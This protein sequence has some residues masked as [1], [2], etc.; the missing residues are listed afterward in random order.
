[1]PRTAFLDFHR[2]CLI[3]RHD[4]APFDRDGAAT[5]VCLFRRRPVGVPLL[6]RPSGHSKA[7]LSHA[8]RRS[9]CGMVGPTMWLAFVH[10][11]SAPPH[12][13]PVARKA[14]VNAARPHAPSSDQWLLQRSSIRC[15][16]CRRGLLL[17]NALRPLRFAVERVCN[18]AWESGSPLYASS[19]AGE[20]A[21]QPC[22][23]SLGDL[24]EAGNQ[25]AA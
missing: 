17:A 12:E 11:R 8:A 24:S 10:A 5:S 19:S 1:M 6:A 4:S 15:E 23:S 25:R 22:R 13:P 14:R 18:R 9:T 21:L 3:L 2:V 7:S 16:I 20:T